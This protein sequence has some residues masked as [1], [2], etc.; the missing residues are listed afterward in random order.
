MS[1]MTVS[2]ILA[3]VDLK[4]PNAYTAEEKIRWL[5]DLDG[6]IFR[7]AILT[8][9]H[10]EASCAPLTSGADE[11]L[12]GPPYGEDVYVHYLIARIAAGNA[13]TARYNQQIALYNAAY[14]QYWN[15][16]NASRAPLHAAERFRL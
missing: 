11:L 10:G 15:A 6:K 2:E 12:I 4:E 13:E 16:L 8:H 1:A 14:A 7:E 3:L 5:S 9:E